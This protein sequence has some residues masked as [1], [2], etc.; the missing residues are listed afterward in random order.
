MCIVEIAA[1]HPILQPGRTIL[2]RGLLEFEKTVFV[3][4]NLMD[5]VMTI[6]LLNTG[7]FYESNP[8]ANFFL[9]RWGFVGMIGFKLVLIG[10][11]LLISN[12]VAIWRFNTARNLL[13]FGSVTVGAVVTY[14][15]YLM[16]TF[17]GWF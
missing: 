2:T 4:I 14:S 13:Y 6:L 7:S 12:V 8:L 11:V 3:V 16:S 15:V 1:E 5:I 10:F 9:E 17:L